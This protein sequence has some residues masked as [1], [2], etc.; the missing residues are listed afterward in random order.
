[1]YGILSQIIMARDNVHLK[2]MKMSPTFKQPGAEDKEELKERYF[3]TYFVR[4]TVI[5][6]TSSCRVLC[7]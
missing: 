7:H 6:L 4:K 3:C 2:Y 5:M 1:M